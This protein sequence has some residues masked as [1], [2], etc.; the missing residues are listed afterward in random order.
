MAHA[1][2]KLDDE[3]DT[4]WE[5]YERLRVPPEQ[6]AAAR[7]ELERQSDEAARNGVYERL[8]SARGKF[9]ID[10]EFYRKLREEDD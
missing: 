2:S 5:L 6:R 8:L 7:A 1:K 4:L 9:A 10:P 3:R